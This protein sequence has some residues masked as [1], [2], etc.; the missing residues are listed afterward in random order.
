MEMP[1]NRLPYREI[2]NK[3]VV[4]GNELHLFYGFELFQLIFSRVLL[5]T[6]QNKEIM[7]LC[8]CVVRIF[9]RHE[10]PVLPLVQAFSDTERALCYEFLFFLVSFLTFRFSK[11]EHTIFGY[12]RELI[13]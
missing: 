3:A 8:H 10:F 7:L 2:L 12:S 5:M 1:G 4:I 9:V 11:R 13:S 6:I